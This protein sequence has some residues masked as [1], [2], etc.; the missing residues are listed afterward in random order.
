MAY[1]GQRRVERRRGA[2]RLRQLSPR[3]W[4]AVGG[5][6]LAF[7]GI[8]IGLI[9]VSGSGSGGGRF[10]QIGDHWHADY[11]LSVCGESVP[12]FPATEGGVHSHGDGLIHIHPTH[13]AEAGANATLARF[14][15][16]AG[17]RLTNDTIRLPSGEEYTNGDPCS[18]DQPGQ[19][20]LRVNGIPTTTIAS[21]VPRNG[22]RLELGF[23]PR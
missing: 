21:Y 4:F 20:F 3:T 6:G 17:G 14:I 16:S 23:E 8:L 5:V 12:A 22:E 9:V 10:P 7:L 19:V 18:N 11:A 2:R 13:P 15:A 1:R